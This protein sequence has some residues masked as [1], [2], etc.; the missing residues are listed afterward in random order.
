MK[1]FH[2]S[3]LKN[4]QDIQRGSWESRNE[5]G[6][7]ASRRI[8][9][10][11]AEAWG[12]GAVF[13]LLEPLPDDWVNNEH[14]KGIW[15][16]FRHD[17]GTLLLELDV[18]PEKD[19]VFVIDRGHIEGVLYENKEGIPQKYLHASKRDGERAYMESKMSLKEYLERAKEL[20]YSMP[21]VIITENFPLERISI[22][23]QQ[24]LIEDELKR[25]SGEFRQMLIRDIQG[26]PELFRWY[27]NREHER[28]L[29][30]ER[31]G[32]FGEK[33]K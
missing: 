33:L 21:E 2:Y 7:G 12:T 15:D 29:R 23:E 4:W 8:G 24:P 14:F 28:E 17:M 3:H 27:E 6:L 31:E 9:Q 10:E 25:Y 30:E 22:S 11:D 19:K 1:V 32:G 18:D 20:G 13:A 26:I 5:P 16:Y